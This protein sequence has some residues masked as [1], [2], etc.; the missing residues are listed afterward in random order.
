MKKNTSK[1]IARKSLAY[2]LA[3][4][5]A[6]ATGAGESEAA[7]SYSGPVNYP[8]AQFTSTLFDL[9]NDTF[10]DILLS[11]YVFGGG[12]YQ[13]ASVQYAPGQIVVS[14]ASFPFYV[15]ALNAGDYIGPSALGVTF[16]GALAYASNANSE[17]DNAS[18]K[19][20]GLSFPSGG[21]TLFAW[22]R[23][24]IDNAAGTFVVKDYAYDTTG[25]PITAGAIPEPGTLGL[26][27][28]GAVG[29]GAMRRRRN[30]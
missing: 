15:S 21:N 24:D 12:N 27:A 2:S 18:D 10:N 1:A 30:K 6:A 17:F 7:I 4:G 20:I 16:S 22:I 19:F 11:N 8:I 25:S 13:G 5:A 29:L 3:A 23:V 14:N 9:D 28:A 26:L